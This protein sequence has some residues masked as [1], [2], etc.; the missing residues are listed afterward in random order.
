VSVGD[1]KFPAAAAEDVTDLKLL[2]GEFRHFRAETRASF[3]LLANKIMG[4][5]QGVE[6]MLV[7]LATRQSRLEQQH[8]ESI[9]ERSEMRR[10]LQEMRGQLDAIVARP[11]RPARR[12]PRK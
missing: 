2:P 6:R 1:D 9:R 7:D 12:K 5:V 11:R 3:E 10:Q 4:A 8:D